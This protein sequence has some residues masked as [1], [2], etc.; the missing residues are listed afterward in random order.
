LG[1][2]LRQ[3]SDLLADPQALQPPM[4]VSNVAEEPAAQPTVIRHV[5]E[6][7]VP[8]AD[9]SDSNDVLVTSRPV[10]LIWTKPNTDEVLE[11][12]TTSPSPK[13]TSQEMSAPDAQSP[14]TA[15]DRLHP[16]TEGLVQNVKMRPTPV[17]KKP[18][19][20]STNNAISATHSV[21]TLPTAPALAVASPSICLEDQ[22]ISKIE[23]SASDRTR[24]A[25]ALEP[26]V[27]ASLPAP[28]ETHAQVSD[29]QPQP[30]ATAPPS[31]AQEEH[32]A[33]ELGNCQAPQGQW[34][35]WKIH[36]HFSR[37]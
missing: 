17:S 35:S 20:A 2:V 30:A 22:A 21:D 31:L 13:T 12:L 24:S 36:R 19:I 37:T 23:E 9:S 1:L 8:H 32:D 34:C 6:N 4:E 33:I 28:I 25:P 7:E 29:P 14:S 27:P 15:V 3:Q 16:C 11:D 10:H 5:I 26:S 18:T